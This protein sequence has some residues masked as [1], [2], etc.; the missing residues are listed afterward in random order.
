MPLHRHSIEPVDGNAHPS[1]EFDREPATLHLHGDLMGDD[2]LGRRC[3]DCF[4]ETV[5][6]KEI[7]EFATD[8]LL[9]PSPN[10]LRFPA[11]FGLRRPLES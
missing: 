10:L 1:A 2:T 5:E 11:D 8:M 7:V 3:G 9:L 6:L 4:D